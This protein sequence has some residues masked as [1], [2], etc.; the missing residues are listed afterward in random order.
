MHGTTASTTRSHNSRVLLAIVGVGG[1]G[2]ACFATG[3]AVS[4]SAQPGGARAQLAAATVPGAA[5]PSATGAAAAATD[6]AAIDPAAASAPS[7]SPT[8]SPAADQPPAAPAS[9]TPVPSPSPAPTLISLGT[10]C[11]GSTMAPHTGFQDAP[12]C[13]ST[14]F[15]EVAAAAND[16]SLL[17]AWAPRV[18]R[19]NQSFTIRVSTRNLVRDRFLP[20]GKG[21]YYIERSFLDLNGLQRGHFHTACRM[22]SN[23]TTAQDPAP[24]PAF[25]KATEDGNGGATPDTVSL[26]ITGLPS[27]GVAQCAV[28]A[29]D[30]SHRIPM[31]QRANQIPAF[32]SVRIRVY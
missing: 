22:L 19:A 30:G 8:A 25:F 14:S 2:L 18:V 17:I 3:V 21:G 4:S 32:D 29:G 31:M 5:D 20:A 28:W 16:P 1:V 12:A 6:P 7:T 15:G 23:T 11:Q 24:V 10:T 9:P 27:A 13:V 26:T